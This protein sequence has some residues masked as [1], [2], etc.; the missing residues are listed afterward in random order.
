MDDDRR[1]RYYDMLSS[2]INNIIERYEKAISRLQVTPK[3]R[4]SLTSLKDILDELK[5]IRKLIMK[6]KPKHVD[7]CDASCEL[8]CPNGRSSS[9]N[10]LVKSKFKKLVLENRLNKTIFAYD[11]NNEEKLYSHEI[12][13]LLP[14][15]SIRDYRA[16]LN[17]LR[18][19]NIGILAAFHRRKDI[20]HFNVIIRRY[21][22]VLIYE[23][24]RASRTDIDNCTKILKCLMSKFKEKNPQKLNIKYIYGDMGKD[25]NSLM[26]CLEFVEDLCDPNCSSLASFRSSN[27]TA[28]SSF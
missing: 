26:D 19:G 15:A 16:A 9:N 21:K 18:N 23:P 10:S 12:L 20:W 11:P 14:F 13:K 27:F 28:K 5:H 25:H 3:S 2:P 7:I 24:M 6:I 22:D 17:I 8:K 4:A 1:Q